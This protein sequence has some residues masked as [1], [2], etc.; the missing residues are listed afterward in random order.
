MIRIAFALIALASFSSIATAQD[1]VLTYTGQMIGTEDSILTG[2]TAPTPVPYSAMFSGF[3]N[4]SGPVDNL[5]LDTQSG[6]ATEVFPPFM[7]NG[8]DA[9]L[10]AGANPFSNASVLDIVTQGGSII[11][12]N[13]SVDPNSMNSLSISANG[14][15]SEFRV[16]GS[17]ILGTCVQQLN[18]ITGSNSGIVPN[19]GPAIPCDLTASTINGTWTV[20]TTAAPEIDPTSALS[21][22]T[23]LMGILALVRGRRGPISHPYAG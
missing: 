17:N 15:A 9:W 11:G 14:A 12:A 23:L 3:L 19:P 21:A 20:K 6:L 18:S 5:T 10:T 13:L 16:F 22:L 8:P 2:G 7:P 1:Y 4:L